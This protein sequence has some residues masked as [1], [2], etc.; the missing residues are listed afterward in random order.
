MEPYVHT[1]PHGEDGIPLSNRDL[2]YHWMSTVHPDITASRTDKCSGSDIS[3]FIASCHPKITKPSPWLIL[4]HHRQDKRKVGIARRSINQH[5]PQY[6]Q[7]LVMI[8]G[9]WTWKFESIPWLSQLQTVSNKTSFT[10]LE[11]AFREHSLVQEISE[12]Y[13]CKEYTYRFITTQKWS[14]STRCERIKA[15]QYSTLINEEAARPILIIQ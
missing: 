8:H 4:Y 3:L 5:R 2:L 13:Y 15:T 7:Q 14:S 11:I 10:D 6:W 1:I 9:M 12:W